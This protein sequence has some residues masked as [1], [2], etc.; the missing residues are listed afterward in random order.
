MIKSAI[1]LGC[2]LASGILSSIQIAGDTA[3]EGREQI[4]ID[5]ARVTVSDITLNPGRPESME[6]HNSDFVTIFL[7]GGTFRITEANGRLRIVK[8]HGGDATFTFKG[9]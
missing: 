8:Y 4:K 5:N 6:K 2:Y 3:S 7:T 1:L 9:A